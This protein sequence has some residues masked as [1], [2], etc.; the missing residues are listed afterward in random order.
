MLKTQW[1]GAEMARS[2][3]DARVRPDDLSGFDYAVG[4]AL[5]ANG[6]Y[7]DALSKLDGGLTAPAFVKEAKANAGDITDKQLEELAAKLHEPGHEA[8]LSGLNLAVRSITRPGLHRS[9]RPMAIDR[10]GHFWRAPEA[11]AQLSATGATPAQ[12]YALAAKIAAA[13]SPGVFGTIA[14]YSEAEQ[15]VADLK[16]ELAEA[17]K[18]LELAWGAADV[19]VEGE[20]VSF[21]R[22]PSVRV[23][24]T[25]LGARVLSA[26]AREVRAAA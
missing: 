22:F 21:R 23:T 1:C 26:A 20:K 24:S 10:I 25:D 19:V 12:G 8:A 4:S 18:A 14:N 6:R 5:E 7:K 13:T 9:T 11:L 17:V 16:A 3:T 2:K 15:L